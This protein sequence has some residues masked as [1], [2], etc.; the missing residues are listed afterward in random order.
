MTYS[1]FYD[2]VIS[3]QYIYNPCLFTAW[4]PYPGCVGD[5]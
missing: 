3:I 5:L 1:V 4:F 2:Y